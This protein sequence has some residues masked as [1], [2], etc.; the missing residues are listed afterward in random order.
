MHFDPIGRLQVGEISLLT[1][2]LMTFLSVAVAWAWVGLLSR[3]LPRFRALGLPWLVGIGILAAAAGLLLTN[4]AF[5]C[6]SCTPE[7]AGCRVVVVGWPMRQLVQQDVDPD[8]VTWYDICRVGIEGS[9]LAPYVNFS[10]PALGIPLAIAL[11]RSRR[12]VAAA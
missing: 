6:P 11:L 1:A 8:P 4:V 5:I 12:R 9:A 2:L 3:L 10:L 7:T